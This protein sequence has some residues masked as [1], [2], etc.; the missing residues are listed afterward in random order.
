[1]DVSTFVS[2]RRTL[3]TPS[4]EIAYTEWGTGPAAVFV[5]GI[6]VSGALWRH[7]IESLRDTT[8]CIAI[9]LPGHGATPPREDASVTAMAQLVA[10]LCEGLGLSQVDLVG[11]DTGGAVSQLVAARHPGLLR[12]LTLTNCDT[13]GNFPPPEMVPVVDLA[14]QGAVAPM[15]VQVAAD[16]AAARESVL[17]GSFEHPGEVPDE[18][19][20]EYL[21]PIG[22]DIERARYFERILA[23]IDPA[24]LTGLNDQLRGL[25]VP[26]LVVWSKGGIAFGLEW[27]YRLRDLIPGAREVVEIEGPL[28]YPE[29]RPAEIAQA[30]RRHWSR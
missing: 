10:D 25:T 15:L 23:A 28:F 9:D 18:A 20:R 1:M 5:P 30:L 12:S 6:T 19:W 2:H 17:A 21:T 26:T 29:E 8:R 27:A 3:A 11:I 24:E 22:G 4:G 13:E 14:R 16:L 7:V